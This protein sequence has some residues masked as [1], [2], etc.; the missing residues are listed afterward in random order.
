MIVN[1]LNNSVSMMLVNGMD[2]LILHVLSTK[3]RPDGPTLRPDG[4][5]LWARRSAQAQNILGF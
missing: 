1:K 3:K 2:A 5:R 4:P